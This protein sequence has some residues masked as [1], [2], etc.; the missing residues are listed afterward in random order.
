MDFLNLIITDKDNT[1]ALIFS[2]VATI[3]LFWMFVL[4][5]RIKRLSATE[6]DKRQADLIKLINKA[7][8]DLQEIH[9]FHNELEGYLENAENR[10]QQSAQVVEMTRFNAYKGD[11]SGG[12]Q[13]FALL[14]LD[15]NGNGAVLTSLYARE[16]SSVFAKPVKKFISDYPLIEE[17]K[18]LLEKAKNSLKKRQFS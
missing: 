14:V 10:I 3:L 6:T 13:S 12:N 1:F 9:E 7:Q 17:E 4:Q 16:H 5:R 18:V 8:E 15:E 11:G 2:L